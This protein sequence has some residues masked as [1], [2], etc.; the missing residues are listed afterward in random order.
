MKSNADRIDRRSILKSGAAALT[1][2]GLSPVI[3]LALL[4]AETQASSITNKGDT[5]VNTVRTKDGAEIY[6]RDWG[7][8]QP[9]VFSHGWPLSSE[10]WS[11]QMLF[12]AQQGYRV[13]AHDRRGHG[14][15][16]QT[17]AH[18]D[19][20]TY[21]DDLAAVMDQLDVKNAV[22]IGHSTGGGEVA[23]YVGRHGTKRL[24]KVVLISAIP[25]LLLKTAANPGGIPMEVWDSFRASL[26]KDPSQFYRD[27]AVLFYGA[28]RPGAKVSQGL[29]DQIWLLSMQGGVQ[30]IYECI[31]ALSETDFTEDLKKFDV[32][33]LLL[34]GEDDQV[35]P[36]A[37][38]AKK[39]AKLIRDVEAIYYPGAP[40]GL[41]ASHFDQVNSDLL[42]FVKKGGTS[43]KAA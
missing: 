39:A 43:S 19:M 23:R 29:L 30:N 25:P 35:V 1:T 4:P 5:N 40:H 13:I 31:K 21:A 27:F 7:A 36:V 10:A 32:P 12:F 17:S 22:L 8:G 3:P 33:T 41:P 16:T 9:I 28:N 42:K 38:T 37:D 15:S 24:A 14:R 26:A 6:Y 20:N 2:L 34:H 18:N 11:G